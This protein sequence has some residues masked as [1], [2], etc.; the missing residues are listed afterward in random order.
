MFNQCSGI[1]IYDIVYYVVHLTMLNT[2]DQGFE[3]NN[4][5]NL[6]HHCFVEITKLIETFPC[7]CIYIENFQLSTSL[8]VRKLFY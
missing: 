3:N 4:F 7:I 5:F 2:Y 6:L 1:N 8:Y